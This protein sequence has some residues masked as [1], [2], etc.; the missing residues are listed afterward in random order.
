MSLHT[1][2]NVVQ[3]IKMYTKTTKLT[4]NKQKIR[5]YYIR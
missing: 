4:T 3:K 5:S 1:H 2:I